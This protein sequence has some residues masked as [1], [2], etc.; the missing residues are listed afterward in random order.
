VK[1]LRWMA[2]NSTLGF[3]INDL[4]RHWL[5]YGFIHGFPRVFGF[6]RMICNDAPLSVARGF[7]ADEWPELAHRASLDTSRLRVKWHWA[8]RYGVRYD[9]A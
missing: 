8:F 5:A 3:F 2:E 7:R 1:V 6:N 9:H 4:H